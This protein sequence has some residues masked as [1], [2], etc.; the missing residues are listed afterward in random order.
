MAK[1]L[2]KMDSMENSHQ[3]VINGIDKWAVGIKD[4]IRYNMDNNSIPIIG[5]MSESVLLVDDYV[6]TRWTFT[7]IGS[8]IAKQGFKVYPF[9]LGMVKV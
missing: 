4:G 3:K 8:L 7:I 5:D 1:D 9:S 2:P 6:N